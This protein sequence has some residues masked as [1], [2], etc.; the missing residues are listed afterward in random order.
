[1]ITFTLNE[2]SVSTPEMTVEELV[3]QQVGATTGVAVAIDGA[4]V[5]RSEW[6]RKIRSGDKVDLLTAVQGG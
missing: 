1:M 2:K 3:E 5:P 4:V 6:T